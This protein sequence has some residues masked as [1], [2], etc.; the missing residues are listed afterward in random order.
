MLAVPSGPQ[1]SRDTPY[2]AD[3]PSCTPRGQPHIRRPGIRHT[4]RICRTAHA[5][6]R[7]NMPQGAQA[8]CGSPYIGHG[9]R[10]AWRP[11]MRSRVVGADPAAR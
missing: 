2:A 4:V 1:V 6:T 9:H 3:V 7:P 10:V 8:P 5:G 11:D